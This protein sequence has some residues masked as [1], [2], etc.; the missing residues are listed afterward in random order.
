MTTPTNTQCSCRKRINAQT[1]KIYAH[2]YDCPMSEH[3]NPDAIGTDTVRDW[4]KEFDSHWDNIWKDFPYNS[5]P[6]CIKAFIQSVLS[7]EKT[8]LLERLE[9]VITD[10]A[11][12]SNLK[13]GTSTFGF[14]YSIRQALAQIKEDV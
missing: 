13:I 6:E 10:E 14:Y 8:Q 3:C 1:V 9:R 12:A 5:I 2:A 7:K 4:E 11:Q